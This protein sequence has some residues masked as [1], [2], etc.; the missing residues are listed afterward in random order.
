MEEGV[1]ETERTGR[2][3]GEKYWFESP[4]ALFS[5]S[6]SSS[7]Q[8]NGSGG[9]SGSEKFRDTFW[10][11]TAQAATSPA[12]VNR[13][14]RIALVVAVLLSLIFWSWW[15]IGVATGIVLLVMLIGYGM[16]VHAEREERKK[17]CASGSASSVLSDTTPL[18]YVNSSSGSDS[19]EYMRVPISDASLFVTPNFRPT[20]TTF[21]NS[22]LDNS[23]FSSTNNCNLPMS[24]S[25]IEQQREK[26]AASKRA[27]GCDG[28][29]ACGPG[30]A[31]ARGRG[32]CNQL[33]D[34]TFPLASFDPRKDIPNPSRHNTYEQV[35]ARYRIYETKAQPVMS[36]DTSS[37]LDAQMDSARMGLGEAD[38]VA[39]EMERAEE[40]SR[41]IVPKEK[42]ATF[43][44]D[45]RL[46]TE[47]DCQLDQK[48]SGR[49]CLSKGRKLEPVTQEMCDG[50]EQPRNQ[51]EKMLQQMYLSTGESFWDQQVAGRKI[52]WRSNPNDPRNRIALQNSELQRQSFRGLHWNMGA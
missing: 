44:M 52:D 30:G 1:E 17:A 19:D 38:A 20:A 14:T 34:D 16:Q 12:N 49:P 47:K 37:L 42:I 51:T 33:C 26:E 40:E 27:F 15:P 18:L 21:G 28:Y 25:L 50:N 29:P 6:P 23:L 5:S 11:D 8:N 4:A 46:A 39:R 35:D 43:G 9:Q 10:P 31:T 2:A 3:T 45:P 48:V 41:R 32:G 13:I 7:C 22:S 24:A 36:A